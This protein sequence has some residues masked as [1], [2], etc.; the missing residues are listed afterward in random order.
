MHAPSAA[1]DWGVFFVTFRV[2][3]IKMP[4]NGSKLQFT[5][6]NVNLSPDKPGVYV[7]Y[8]DGH[9]IYY[10]SSEKSIRSRLQDHLAGRE[11]QCTQVTDV[12][13]FEIAL[14]PLKREQ[15]LILEYRSAFG[16][17]PL[18]NNKTP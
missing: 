13:G 17:L 8:V 5:E 9:L 7:L 3:A 4:V 6:T 10:G 16:V 14:K 1:S 11:G 18:C 15:E 2:R 12:F